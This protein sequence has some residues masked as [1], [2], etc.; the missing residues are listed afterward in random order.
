MKGGTYEWGHWIKSRSS[1]ALARAR[2][3]KLSVRNANR[4]LKPKRSLFNPD[5]FKQIKHSI[6]VSES[7][8]PPLCFSSGGYVNAQDAD[9]EKSPGV[10]VREL[11]GAGSNAV[12]TVIDVRDYLETRFSVGEIITSSTTS[13]TSGLFDVEVEAGCRRFDLKVRRPDASAVRLYAR[14]GVGFAPPLTLMDDD[15]FLESVRRLNRR[16]P[17]SG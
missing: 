16:F 3:L 6:W 13:V 7:Y 4:L 15:L 9:K 17:I 11:S 1:G 14:G 8:T 10:V 5:S 12:D 2:L